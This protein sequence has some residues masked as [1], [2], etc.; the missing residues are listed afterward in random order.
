[1]TYE[2]L[3]LLSWCEV[4]IYPEHDSDGTPDINFPPSTW[5]PIAID[6]TREASPVASLASLASGALQ[7]R[8]R[9]ARDIADH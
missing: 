9:F 6:P 8:N 1:M 7:K 5:P 2:A 4:N 3:S